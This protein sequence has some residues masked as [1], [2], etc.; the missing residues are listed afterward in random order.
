MFRVPESHSF[1]NW[2]LR[3][4]IKSPQTHGYFIVQQSV[5][6]RRR[7][8]KHMPFG[9]IGLGIRS[10]SDDGSFQPLWGQTSLS[11]ELWH[12]FVC[13]RACGLSRSRS[14][15]VRH[16]FASCAGIRSHWLHITRKEDMQYTNS[17]CSTL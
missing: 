8:S 15:F 4:H 11:V 16:R 3:Q 9:P 6:D 14:L 10:S 5:M 2:K 7:L 13:L 1:Q 12:G 17:S